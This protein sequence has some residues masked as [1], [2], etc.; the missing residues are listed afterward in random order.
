MSKLL[1]NANAYIQ[2]NK[3]R[4][5]NHP[6]FH[7]SPPIGWMNDPNGLCYYNGEYHLYYQHNPYKIH[8]DLMYWGHA[9]SRDLLQWQDHPVA[10]APEEAYELDG[11]FSGSAIEIDDKLYLM[12]TGHLDREGVVLQ[13]QNI[14]ISH[15]GITFEKHTD[16]PVL[17]A[18]DLPQGAL[19]QDFRDPKVFKYKD[20]Y[21]S[22]IVGRP[23]EVGGA[24]L[25]YRSED[26]LHW[27]YVGVLAKSDQGKQEIW[28]CPDLMTLNQEEVLIYSII[29][30]AKDDGKTVRPNMHPTEYKLGK[31]DLEEAHGDWHTTRDLDCGFNFYAPQTFVDPSGERIMI[32]WISPWDGDEEV[33]IDNGWAGLMS[34]P[35]VL[36]VDQGWL[37]QQP[38][39]AIKDLRKDDGIR[40][41]EA[42]LYNE[43]KAFDT[44]NGQHFDLSFTVDISEA[45]EFCIEIA[46]GKACT[47]SLTY[48]VV[49]QEWI[50]DR[51]NNGEKNMLP[52]TANNQW[53]G[54]R[55]IRQER[56]I[57]TM[58]VRVLMDRYSVEIFA[59]GGR[60]VFTALIDP[61]E[62]GENIVFSSRGK[63][64]LYNVEFYS[65]I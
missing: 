54:L 41:Q 3:D 56:V 15:D 9:T 50:F 46:K 65:L 21:W 33:R 6:K 58:D 7:Y 37:I 42:M 13:N 51:R 10:L 17:D 20:T 23:E 29:E 19:A 61:H 1:D 52:M 32:G 25:L 49:G 55:T 2:K 44:M 4:T 62:D 30:L 38:I 35:R 57:K 24:V 45:R 31:V 53:Y 47:T 5:K 59:D 8:W 11:C 43:S 12:Y 14:A 36:S 22:V 16:N 64:T 39:E 63:S 34:I 48:D 27:D 28:E 18:K 40:I 26:M 60:R